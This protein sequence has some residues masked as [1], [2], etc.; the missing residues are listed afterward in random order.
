M[1]IGCIY[2]CPRC[3][4]ESLQ[5]LLSPLAMPQLW[6][7][8]TESE[9]KVS[10]H[11]IGK[12][13]KIHWVDPVSNHESLINLKEPAKK[14]RAALARWIER[15]VIDDITEGVVRLIIAETFSAGEE[16]PDEAII[17]WI[18]E[19]LITKIE[20]GEYKDVE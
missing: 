6:M 17:G 13:A 1:K 12:E 4:I 8:L 14:G 20:I 5:R 18:P 15:G 10:K 11:L 16:K 19:D 2:I 9:M 7:G 3:G